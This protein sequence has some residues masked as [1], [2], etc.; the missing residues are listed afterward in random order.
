MPSRYNGFAIADEGLW[1]D[2]NTSGDPAVDPRYAGGHGPTL[3]ALD[4]IIG[5]GH[6][7]W[8]GGDYVNTEM[9]NLL[10]QVDDQEE[11]FRFIQR[12]GGS[13][14][15]GLRIAG[16]AQDTET[17]RL[18]GLFGGT[19]GNLEYRLAD[20]SG[21]N[22]ENPTLAEMTAAAI[23]VL[24]RN[25]NGFALMIE[26]G[27]VDWASHENN[28]DRMIGEMTDFI[29]AVQL[30]VEWIDDPS[31]DS[32]WQ[33]TLVVITADH[34]TGY[35]SAAPGAYADQP[36]G[37]INAQ[38]LKLEKTIQG[39]AQRASWDDAN[40]NAIIDPGES[41]YWAWNLAGHTNSLIP[42][43]VKGVGVELFEDYLAEDDPVRGPYMDNTDIFNVLD[44]VMVHSA[45][46]LHRLYLPLAR[47]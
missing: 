22:A 29:E 35:L 15:G 40:G 23:K 1:G 27:A 26:S 36:L 21:L 46:R 14:D 2:P 43:Y 45:A 44:A 34:E 7:D 31:N 17:T 13:S 8:N 5:A 39:S 6:P 42:L 37:S 18:V 38:T 28:M 10:V 25:P 47:R 3:P 32:S 12:I 24:G 20:G 16:A 33:N 30:V 4:V 9:V 19:G 41:V 11:S